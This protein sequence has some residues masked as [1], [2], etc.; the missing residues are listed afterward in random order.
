MIGQDEGVL[1]DGPEAPM[2]KDFS[3]PTF[4]GGLR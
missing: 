2:V 1:H 3:Q 4:S